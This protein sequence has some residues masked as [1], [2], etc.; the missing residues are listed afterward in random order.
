MTATVLLGGQQ[1]FVATVSHSTNSAVVW[2]V[3]GVTGGNPTM[4]TISVSG[5]YTAPV[6][7]STAAAV[8]IVATSVEDS[9]RSSAAQATISRDI[10]ISISPQIASVELGATQTFTAA[11]NSAGSPNRA[12][13]WILSGSN[14]PGACGSVDA[15]GIYTAPQIL[16]ATPSVTLTAVSVADSSRAAAV[17]VNLSSTFSIS[18]NGPATV[19]AGASATYAAT[20]SAAANSNPDREVSWSVAGNGCTAHVCGTI[21][22]SGAYTAPAIPPS[23]ATVKIVATPLSDPTKI[24]SFPISIVPVIG[25]AITPA[26]ASVLLGTTQNFQAMVTGAADT[27][28]TWDVNGVVGG[29]ATVGSILNSQISPNS[30]T[31]TSPQILPAGGIVTVRARSN[32]SPGSSASASVTLIS[33]ITL[34]LNPT[35]S[36]VA[37]GDRQ[38]FSLQIS[39]TANQTATWTVNG[40]S[41]GSPAIGRICVTGSNPCQAA[42]SSGLGSV[43]YVAPEGMPSPN[44]V[45]ITATS[46]V[47]S[48]K[49]ASSSITILPHVSVSIQPGNITLA[50]T[51]PIR[52]IAVV[53]GSLDQ[54]VIWRISGSACGIPANCGSIDA[55]GLYTA[56]PSVPS[57]ALISVIATSTEDTSQSGFATVILGN[58][59]AIFS[60]APT[61]AYAGT[62]GGFTLLVTG[63]NFG[64]TSPGPG[65][66]ILVS[67]TPRSTNCS[68]S[69]QCITSLEAA[70]LQSAGNLNLQLQNPDGTLSNTQ[71]FVVLAPGSGMSIIPLTPSAPTSTG[72]DIVVVDL[73]TNGGSGASGNV[74]LSLAAI[75]PYSPSIGSCTL[76]GNPVILQPPP[77]GNGSGDLCVFSVSGL[78]A[79]FSFSVSGPNV[80]DVAVINREPL[81]LGILH[82]TLSVPSTAPTGARTLFITNP[83]GDMAAGSGAIV[84]K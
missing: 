2:S 75:G 56:P 18:I 50:N 29:N 19:D 40:I 1:I 22:Q 51:E 26:S 81:G 23:P 31:Y 73:S 60:F 10:S 67:G 4:G 6:N 57:P 68:S 14:C 46:Q 37:V 45:V 64:A 49:S 79:S 84:V 43:D 63:I 55:T 78:S 5:T 3:N 20:I 69:T 47:D 54:Q 36:F 70:D 21:T 41:G 52:F 38:T 7:L 16:P 15:G 65:S 83:N 33:S 17:A 44:P 80:P 35:T 11:I 74:S 34:A 77:F 27:T 24:V 13:T 82:L 71:I 58:G 62:A 59:P 53:T 42:L 72:N 66:T 9:A 39:G 28:V 8:S 25:V 48:T 30:T 12:I 32:A 61:S 76:G